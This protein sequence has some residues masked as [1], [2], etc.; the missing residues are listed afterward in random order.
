MTQHEDEMNLEQMRARIV[1][2]ASETYVNKGREATVEEIAR[3]AGLSVPV[4]YQFLKKPADI[5]MLILENLHNQF[6]QRL[7]EAPLDSADAS[8]K[9]EQAVIH[10]CHVVHENRNKF[11]LLYRSSR[12]LDREG[13]KQIMQ[14]ELET[15]GIFQ[16]IIEEGNRAGVFNVANPQLTA[17]DIVLLGHMWTLKAW[18]FKKAGV[19]LDRFIAQQLEVIRAMV[20]GA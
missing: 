7:Q 8:E 6:A 18:H 9:L 12:D 11:M 15:V 10:F 3:Q 4:A 14:L 20:R 16:T 5:M 1:R 17:Y 2:A 19:G 13:R